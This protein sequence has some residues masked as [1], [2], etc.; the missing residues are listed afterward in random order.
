P[1]TCLGQYESAIMDFD[2]A[3]RLDPDHANA[4]FIRGGGKMVLGETREAK[5]DWKTALKLATQLGNVKLKKQIKSALRQF[6]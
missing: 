2:T 6:G 4:Y 5:Q 3:I 1:K